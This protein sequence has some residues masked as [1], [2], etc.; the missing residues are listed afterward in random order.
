MGCGFSA[1][2]PLKEVSYWG[3]PSFAFET[4]SPALFGVAGSFTGLNC[5]SLATPAQTLTPTITWTDS[6]ASTITTA[7]CSPIVVSGTGSLQCDATVA[8]LFGV[9]TI[10]FLSPGPDS[11]QSSQGV[12]RLVFTIHSGPTPT[13]GTMIRTTFTEI[14]AEATTSTYYTTTITIPPTNCGLA[15]R[16]DPTGCNADN[17]LRALKGNSAAASSFCST[18]TLLSATEGYSYP[19]FVSGYSTT[20]ARISSACSCFAGLSPATATPT[21]TTVTNAPGCNADN[22]L[23]ALRQNPSSASGFCTTY[24]L[25]SATPGYPY[26]AYVTPWSTTSARISSACSC[27]SGKS[28]ATETPPPAI[29]PYVGPEGAYLF[30]STISVLETSSTATY[31]VPVY[32]AAYEDG[33]CPPVGN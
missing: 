22:V 2:G 25:S 27:F 31:V 1:V 16:A 24:T 10:D 17:V 32:E 28:P 5:A 9:A 14:I 19:P 12:N 20:S 13:A 4:T 3:T 29:T 33:E 11:T 7:P 8:S 26:P 15:K 6:L 18:Y 21:P 23:R 30:G